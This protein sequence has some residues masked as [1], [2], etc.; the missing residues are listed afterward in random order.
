MFNIGWNKTLFQWQGWPDHGVPDESDF[1]ALDELVELVAECKKKD[2]RPI[3]LHCRYDFLTFW[4]FGLSGIYTYS[5]GVGRTGTLIAIVN[6]SLQIWHLKGL[7]KLDSK[8]E[9]LFLHY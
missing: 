3:L 2:A 5:A 4:T 8:N 7:G 1:P 9:F 6:L